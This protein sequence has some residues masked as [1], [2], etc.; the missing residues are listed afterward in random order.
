MLSKFFLDR[1][2]FA[3]V[4]AIVLMVLGCLSIHNLPISQYPP[5]A[6]PSIA[7]TATY[8][9]ASA[10]TVENSVTQ[11]IEQKMTG[12]DDLL[13]LSATS[14]SSG[15]ARIELTFKPGTD[16]D[17]A[18]AK[19]QNK[20]QLAQ[21][22]LPASVQQAGVSVNKSTRNFLII[23]GLVSEDGSMDGNDLRITPNPTWRK[24]CR[25]FPASARSWSSARS[26]PCAFGSIRKDSRITT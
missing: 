10:E 15:A 25:A 1:P 20:L 19:V 13:Y 22:S 7:I 18:W 23:V 5:I 26:T 11:I 24:S 3:W 12:F 14:E 17:L 21:S 4:I 6:P 2:V 8:P 16:P 9:G